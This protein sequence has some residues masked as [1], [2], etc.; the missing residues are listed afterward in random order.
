MVGV[1]RDMTDHHRALDTQRILIAELQ[2]R[3]RNLVGVVRSL[4]RKTM[5]RSESLEDF[6][7]R[8]GQ[9]LCALGRVQDLLSQ[10]KG[11][12]RVTFDDLI[13]AELSAHGA[14]DD[15]EQ[16]SLQGPSGIRL[17]SSTVQTLALALHELATNASKY[18]AL[19]D[20]GHL[21]MRWQLQHVQG[22]NEPMLEVSWPETG[23]HLPPSDAPTTGSGYGREL[24]ERALPYQL[25][26]QTSFTIATDG[27]RCTIRLP[28]SKTNLSRT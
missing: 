14:I 3:T 19:R 16:V 25:D 2:H 4:S 22:S 20:G 9:R 5:E 17:R 21:L 15:G 8:F 23:V 11:D 18:G 10:L 27:V 1:M 26:A 13:R 7:Q 6:Y 12:D 28:V 24:I